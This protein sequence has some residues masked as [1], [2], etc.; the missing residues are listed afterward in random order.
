MAQVPRAAFVPRY[1]E[2]RALCET[3]HDHVA[4]GLSCGEQ[5]WDD[6]GILVQ[7]VPARVNP[8]AGEPVVDDWSCECSV[9][10]GR[11]GLVQWLGL[12]WMNSSDHRAEP[13]GL[14]L[15]CLPESHR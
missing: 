14:E 1:A 6:L 8:K 12:A 9:A 7:N 3:V 11:I 2:R 15:D 10:R 13:G 5:T 4:R